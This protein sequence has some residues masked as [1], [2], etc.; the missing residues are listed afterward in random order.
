MKSL[1][2]NLANDLL[3]E[4]LSDMLKRAEDGDNLSAVDVVPALAT[5]LSTD[6]RYPKGHA[7]AGQP[8]PVPD[9]V[10]DYLAKAFRRIACGTPAAEALGLVVNHAPKKY[11]HLTLR[12]AAF[13]MLQ[14]LDDC[15]KTTKDQAARI[16]ADFFNRAEAAKAER[17][18]GYTPVKLT[19]T[20]VKDWFRYNEGELLAINIGRKK[21]RIL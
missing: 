18:E 10:R 14:V 7:L 8:M 6:N 12:T 16:A 20:A 17:L 1:P 19:K 3:T 11:S 2:D 13:V 9:F 21:H 15:P 5:V 4:N